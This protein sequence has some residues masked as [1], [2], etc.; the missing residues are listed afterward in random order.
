MT[1]NLSSNW[2]K[3][4][5]SSEICICFNPDS[6]ISTLNSK[7]LKLADY[8]IHLSSNISSTESDVNIHK[9]KAWT[10]IDRL[11]NTCKSD[12]W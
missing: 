9:G 2:T 5:T 6:V 3:S 10:A 8:Y 7:P 4:Y 11:T 1:S 12:L